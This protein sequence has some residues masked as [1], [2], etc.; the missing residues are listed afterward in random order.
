MVAI[1][2]IN[3]NHTMRAKSISSNKPASEREK[4]ELDKSLESYHKYIVKLARM[5]NSPK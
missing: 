3:M 1:R 2:Q 5:L 4:F